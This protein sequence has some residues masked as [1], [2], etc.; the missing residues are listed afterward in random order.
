MLDTL[1]YFLRAVWLPE[2]KTPL[3]KQLARC[4]LDG[5]SLPREDEADSPLVLQ[6]AKLLPP[7]AWGIQLEAATVGI[8]FEL[9][10][11]IEPTKP[12]SAPLCS[13]SPSLAPP[14]RKKK[15]FPS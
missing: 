14:Q 15:Y 13:T 10:E 5:T 6:D 3:P 2:D 7:E 12:N 4:H 8:H 9:S 1:Y 11:P